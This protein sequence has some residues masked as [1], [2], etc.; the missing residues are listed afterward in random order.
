MFQNPYYHH[1]HPCHYSHPNYYHWPPSLAPHRCLMQNCYCR[2]KYGLM[3][4]LCELED[5]LE[6]P[7][8]ILRYVLCYKQRIDAHTYLSRQNSGSFIKLIA[9][10]I[11]LLIIS[12]RIVH[13]HNTLAFRRSTIVFWIR[14]WLVGV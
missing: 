12:I 2:E 14:I 7:V 11:K 1:L 4:S 8:D 10:T 9:I 13:V 5:E 6:R 3:L